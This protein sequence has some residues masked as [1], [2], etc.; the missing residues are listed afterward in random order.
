[1]YHQFSGSLDASDN[2]W[3]TNSD[4]SAYVSASGVTYSPWLVL[5]ITASPSTITTGGTT[6]ISANLT[7]H[8]DGTTI[9]AV[10]GTTS[11]PDGTLVA[12]T[13]TGGTVSPATAYTE[14]GVASTTFTPSGTGTATITATVGG[15]SVTVPVTV[16]AAG[17]TAT[18]IVIDPGTSSTV[19]A[20]VDGHGVY[21]STNSGSVWSHLSL[22]LGA[23]LQIRTLAPFKATGSPATTVYA[24]SYGGGVYKSTD[25]GAIWSTCT[26]LTNQNVLS[27]VTNSTGA[28]YAGTENGVYTST[29]DCA[30]WI[31]MNTGLP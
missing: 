9:S 31:P 27:L 7:Y 18:S 15:Q 1:V 23:N 21:K 12:F 8:T 20:G 2:W 17:V 11:A 16:S 30:S 6:I 22:P 24:G 4:P 25:S 28:L 3:G 19:Y 14:S 10:T 29:D 5:G 26:P 13:A